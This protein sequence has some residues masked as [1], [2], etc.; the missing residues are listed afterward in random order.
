MF[1]ILE[2]GGGNCNTFRYRLTALLPLL[3]FGTV[4]FICY[5]VVNICDIVTVVCQT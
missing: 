3:M 2:A 4:N 5:S 1:V